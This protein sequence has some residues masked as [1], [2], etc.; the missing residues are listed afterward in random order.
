MLMAWPDVIV[1][2]LGP[3][4]ALLLVSGL[5]TTRERLW[6][7]AIL[8]WTVLW[9]VQPGA[10]A[11]QIIRGAGVMVTGAFVAGVLWRPQRLGR[12]IGIAV[13]VGMA[14]TLWW[15]WLLGV[16]WERVEFALT[17]ATWATYQTLA[18][19]MSVFDGPD[20]AEDAAAGIELAVNLFPGMTA[21]GA[22]AGL[23]VAWA[24]YQRVAVRPIGGPAPPFTSFRGSDHLLWGMVVPLAVLI[25]PSGDALD[26]VAV[27]ALLVFGTIYVTRGAAILTWFMKSKSP[28]GSVGLVLLAVA[29]LFVLPIAGSGLLL[30]GIV[31][32]WIDIRR[33]PMPPHS[34]RGELP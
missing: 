15:S 23:L 9:L 26:L 3:I 12:N 18:R 6:L 32:T 5:S 34:T 2:A 24:V 8:A 25:S 30:L 20:A 28:L 7:S 33:R 10:I 21:L 16:T 13:T 11:T 22:V 4:G 29:A 1:F 31:D 14:G 27:N 17:R 19:S